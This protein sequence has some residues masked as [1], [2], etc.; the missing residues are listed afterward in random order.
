MKIIKKIFS[1]IANFIDKIIVM[2]VT[3]FIYKITGNKNNSG[4]KDKV[5]T[6]KPIKKSTI[7][8]VHKKK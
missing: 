3:K 1:G 2:P 4:G 8:N 7:R 6:A 5:K